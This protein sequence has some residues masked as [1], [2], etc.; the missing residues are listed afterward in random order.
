MSISSS[1]SSIWRAHLFVFGL[2]STSPTC[3][4]YRFLFFRFC[5]AFPIFICVVMFLVF[6]FQ[7]GFYHHLPYCI[8]HLFWFC[9][10]HYVFRRY[11][12]FVKSCFLSIGFVGSLLVPIFPEQSCVFLMF[13]LFAFFSFPCAGRVLRS[14]FFFFSSYSPFW[15]CV[16][17]HQ[18]IFRFV[19][20]A[21]LGC[22]V[23]HLRPGSPLVCVVSIAVGCFFILRRILLVC[24][25]SSFVLT[26]FHSQGLLGFLLH[27]AI[28][29]FVVLKCHGCV[30]F[31]IMLSTCWFLIPLFL[32]VF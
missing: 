6:H 14:H 16:R 20:L 1:Q 9:F 24:F 8:P 12:R 15:L 28:L 7:V 31:T 22:D 21:C 4:Q 2:Y 13:S 27:Q 5:R 3:S 10:P 11:F 23:V 30:S 32:F 19:A 17:C 29:L 25:Q 18:P 26:S